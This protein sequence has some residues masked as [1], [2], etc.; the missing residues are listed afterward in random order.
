MMMA[1]GLGAD[2]KHISFEGRKEDLKSAAED[3]AWAAI[4]V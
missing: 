4:G 2:I 1:P 3:R